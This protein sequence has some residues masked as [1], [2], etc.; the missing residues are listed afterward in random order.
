MRLVLAVVRS[1]GERHVVRSM[2]TG[3]WQADKQQHRPP[4]LISVAV[5]QLCP[6]ESRSSAE[7][8]ND[9]ACSMPRPLPKITTQIRQN[10][11]R[12]ATQSVSNA[13]TTDSWHT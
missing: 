10:L 13:L 4:P 1:D 9:A 12:R 2:G 5:R 11:R 3:R 8:L 6:K 7:P